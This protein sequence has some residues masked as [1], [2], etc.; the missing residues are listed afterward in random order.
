[1]IDSVSTKNTAKIFET[2]D[3]VKSKISKN[4]IG[5]VVIFYMK[6]LRGWKVAIFPLRESWLRFDEGKKIIFKNGGGRRQPS[7]FFNQL[8]CKII[9]KNWSCFVTQCTSE[10]KFRSKADSLLAKKTKKR[11]FIIFVTLVL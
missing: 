3:L 11:H 8:L 6:H 4:R 2:L 10:S 5:S 1:M 9:F 7:I